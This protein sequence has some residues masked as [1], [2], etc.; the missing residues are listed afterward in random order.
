MIEKKALQKPVLATEREARLYFLLL[1]AD[2]SPCLGRIE[3]PLGR[4][5]RVCGVCVACVRRG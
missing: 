2:V 5:W 4:R 3:C 1:F